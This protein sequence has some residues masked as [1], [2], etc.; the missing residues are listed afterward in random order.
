MHIL[1]LTDNFPP[2]SNAPANRTY[3]HSKIWVEKGVDV[4]VITC[5]PNFPNGKVFRNYRNSWYS[6][7]THDG[8]RIVRVKTFITANEGFLLRT[9]DYMSFMFTSFVA[10]LL[11]RKVDVVVG[12]SPQ[13]F[14][15]CSAWMISLLKRVPFVFELRDLWPASI[16]AVGAMKPGLTLNLIEKLEIFLYKRASLIVS[17]TK[18]FRKDLVKRGIDP[19]KITIVYNGVDLSFFASNKRE[20]G[21]KTDSC[22]Q[23]FTVGYVG[24]LGMAHGLEILIDA[25][26]IL[27]DKPEFHFVVAGAG[28][29]EKFLREKVETL[30]LTNVEFLGQVD[31][32]N[33]PDLLSSMDVS[34]I[35]LKNLPLFKTVIP[36]KVFEAIAAQV[37]VLISVPQGEATDLVEKLGSGRVV[38]PENSMRL[39]EEIEFLNRNPDVLQGIKGSIETLRTTVDR[40]VQA[41]NM[42]A[43]IVGVVHKENCMAD[44]AP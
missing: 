9:L 20:K 16:S 34:L 12:T 17:V 36:S 18:S 37:P 13:F 22:S 7:E 42:L 43:Q 40:K 39:A 21:K 5:A 6:A 35:S 27:S 3:E 14:T 8:I 1:F 31:R 26:N 32:K 25:A 11:Q 29:R 19:A 33:V 10:G 30:G 38:A 4:T 2:E 23:P 44:L 15:V 28:A 24:T 41:E